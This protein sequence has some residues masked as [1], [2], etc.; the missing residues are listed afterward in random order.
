[1]SKYGQTVINEKRVNHE[2]VFVIHVA[3]FMNVAN[4]FYSLEATAL[5]SYYNDIKI[6]I[7]MLD[8]MRDVY[9]YLH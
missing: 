4:Y 8:K 1:M 9:N 7:E 2:Y 3:L 6:F 5:K